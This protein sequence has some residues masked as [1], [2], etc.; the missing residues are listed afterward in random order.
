VS[1]GK[2]YTA[3]EIGQI[4]AWSLEGLKAREIAERLGRTLRATHHQIAKA[5]AK[6]HKR[7]HPPKTFKAGELAAWV[8]KL[9]LPGVPDAD[10]AAILG[11]GRIVVTK[12]RI[13]LG[14][15]R[16]YFGGGSFKRVRPVKEGE[17][18]SGASLKALVIRYKARHPE[19]TYAEIAERVR[20]HPYTVGLILR[21]LGLVRF[22]RER[23]EEYERTCGHEA[24]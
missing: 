16:R 3:K 17:K 6:A 19:F 12:C 13:R 11:T 23:E 8:R 9:S 21:N 5:R 14:I 7:R 22:I 1:G 4:L 20:C 2:D 10:I 24:D 15:P 18:V